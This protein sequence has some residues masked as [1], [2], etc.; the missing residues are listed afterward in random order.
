METHLG[1]RLDAPPALQCPLAEENSSAGGH[2]SPVRKLVTP[3][4]A[5]HC[6]EAGGLGGGC[7][8]LPGSTRHVSAFLNM[9]EAQKE[10]A[11]SPIN[12]ELSVSGP[13]G[14]T[15]CEGGRWASLGITV[16]MVAREATAVMTERLN[17]E[18]R[19]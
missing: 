2:L 5:D 19:L 8:W 1:L 9:W 15:V 11:L 7:G 3:G 14:G 16:D 6:W 4:T 10:A 13:L 12:L 17:P 18:L